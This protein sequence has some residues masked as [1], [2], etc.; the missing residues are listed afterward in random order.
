MMSFRVAIGYNDRY[1]KAWYH[2]GEIYLRQERF[3]LAESHFR[4]AMMINGINSNV[5]I[6]LGL[7]LTATHDSN[8][9]DEA[10]LLLR[11]CARS[12]PKN[13]MPHFDL[14]RILLEHVGTKQA[15]EECISECEILIDLCPREAQFHTILGQA[16]NKIGN[17][18][19][20]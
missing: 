3:E 16:Y 1:W 6:R 18:R 9:V 10:I 5:Q 4:R 11:K 17:F 15:I 13:S 19:P 12:N 7:A 20:S 8:K 2:L 14:A